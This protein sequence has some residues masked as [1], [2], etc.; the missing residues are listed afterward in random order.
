MEMA[1]VY[2]L[3]RNMAASKTGR[4]ETAKKEMAILRPIGRLSAG[5]ARHHKELC[6]ESS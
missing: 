6:S 5:E 1:Q 2:E 3:L 4:Q